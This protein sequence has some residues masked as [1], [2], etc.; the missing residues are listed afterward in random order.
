MRSVGVVVILAVA[1]AL[2]ISML[3]ARDAVGAKINA[4]RASTGNTIT[5]SPAGFGGGGFGSGGNPLTNAQITGLLKIPNVTSVQAQLAARLSSTQT[6]LV[7]PISAGSLGSRFG[8]GAAGA[9]ASGS[10][11]SFVVPVRVIG[12][13][14]PGNALVGGA[15]WRRHREADGRHHI[16]RDVDR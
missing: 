11:G 3:I 15:N 10:A 4:V 14:A 6:N 12:T 13:N 7:S 8:G 2:A 1:I 16:Q 5:V 9:G